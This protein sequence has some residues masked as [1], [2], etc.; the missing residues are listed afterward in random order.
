M[1]VVLEVAV[2]TLFGGINYPTAAATVFVGFEAVVLAA[3]FS[4]LD[5]VAT[6]PGSSHEPLPQS[7]ED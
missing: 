6:F 3:R 2:E 7:I 5:L 1:A 4:G